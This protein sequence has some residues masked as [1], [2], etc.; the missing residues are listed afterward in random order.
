M[1]ITPEE[2]VQVVCPKIRDA[3]WAHFFAPETVARGK[4]LGLDVFG[5]YLMGRGGVLGDV[6]WQVVH[7]AFGYFNPDVVREMWNSGKERVAPRAAGR[8][9][10]ECCGAVGRA[11]LAGIERLDAFCRAAGAVNDAAD[12]AGLPLF[13]AIS[14][15]PLAEDDPARA[16]QLVSVLR[17]FRGSTHLLAVVASGLAP[18]EA[19]FLQRPEAMGMFGWPDG[20]VPDV[21]DEHR[22]RLAE[23]EALTD[24]LVLPAYSVLDPAGAASLIEGMEAIEVALK[25]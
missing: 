7:S 20:E 21:G 16:M 9:F 1:A 10:L 25:S 3:G 12:R 5:F 6:E 24:K 17:E 23:A 8:A 22:A 18:K 13:A 11:R 19:H 14:A 15:E 4:E 2:L